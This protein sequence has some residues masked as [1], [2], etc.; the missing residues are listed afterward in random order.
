MYRSRQWKQNVEL[1]FPIFFDK[2]IFSE[3]LNIVYFV[4]IHNS[5]ISVRRKEWI[6]SPKALQVLEISESLQIWHFK[7]LM[8]NYLIDNCFR[9]YLSVVH[10]VYWGHCAAVQSVPESVT[11]DMTASSRKPPLQPIATAGRNANVAHWLPATK[12]PDST[13]STVY[14][15]IPTL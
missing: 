1:F 7:C 15:A 3:K 6:F 9:T 2:C 10:V 8:V 4:I 14:S 12:A 13:S 5:Q 11:K